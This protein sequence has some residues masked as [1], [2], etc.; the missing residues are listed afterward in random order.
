MILIAAALMEEIRIVLELCTGCTR[1][2]I[3]G[4]RAW[5]TEFRGKSLSCLRT[6]VGPER[7]GKTLKEFLRFHRPARL[8]LIGYGGA[9]DPDLR[10]GELI[11]G[12]R[13]SCLS[14]TLEENPT[15][16]LDGTW[17]LQKLG[18]LSPIGFTTKHGNLLTSP[19]IVGDPRCKQVLYEKFKASVID[20]ETGALARILEHEDLPL[21]CVRAVTDAAD[22]DFL[23]PFSYGPTEGVV[24]KARKILTAGDW[25]TRYRIWQ[26]N[27]EAARIALRA[28]LGSQLED[29]VLGDSS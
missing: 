29:F 7:A 25:I 17:K 8:L 10:V 24:R 13:V 1:L 12:D 5:S 3:P 6:G 20:M 16:I 28:F 27:A 23:T 9:L 18:G 15:V 11:T 14:G 2:K 26:R 4:V 21:S 22:D 19:R